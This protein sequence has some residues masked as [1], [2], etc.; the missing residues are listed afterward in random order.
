M[1]DNNRKCIFEHVHPAMTQINLYT[2]AV[3]SVFM[4]FMWITK[5]FSLLQADSKD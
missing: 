5:E 2:C 4:G 1:K 3:W